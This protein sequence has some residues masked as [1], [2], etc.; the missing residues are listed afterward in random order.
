M[1]KICKENTNIRK[2]LLVVLTLFLVMLL[3]CES[4][5]ASY[6]MTYL[7]GPGDYIMMV[8]ETEELLNE[9][10]PSYFDIMSDGS[11]RINNIDV[12]LVNEMHKKNIKVVP[13]LSNHWN[14]EAGRLALANSEEIANEIVRTI[15]NF[16]LDGINVDIENVTLPDRDAYTNLVKLLR[17]KLPNEKSVVVS[18]AANPYGYETG[19]HASYDYKMLGEYAD[20]LMVMAY[21]EHFEGGEPGPVASIQFAEKSI[22]Y[23]LKYVPKEKI[24]LGI[25]FFGRYW[26]K[27]TN[28]GGK[29]VSL[30]NIEK[31]KDKYNVVE[32][33]SDVYESPYI[34]ININEG[35]KFEIG[36][37]ILGAGEYE[38]WYENEKS[39]LKKI[40]IVNK[41]GIKG[42]GSWKL[43]L[44]NS[45][46]WAKI[47]GVVSE[48]KSSKVYTDLSELHWA[49]KHIQTIT[50]LGIVEG[51]ETGEFKPDNYITRA[52]MAKIISEVIK[53]IEN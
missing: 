44:E 43:G 15:K 6:M 2:K 52:E 16:N 23:A 47:K 7:Y 35:E 38:I 3:L 26:D 29:A 36:N 33:Y 37:E 1:N 46:I 39:L 28:S 10:S 30:K 8:S 24:V 34:T 4:V 9:V 25:P 45:N 41:Y 18:V 50:N 21:D 19:W 20:Y 14:R 11:L 13:F 27:N 51:Y 32:K 53:M 49:Y 12:N 31:I 42:V 22:E 40:E 17:E 48:T 5:Y